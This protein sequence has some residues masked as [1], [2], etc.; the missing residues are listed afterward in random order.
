MN[1]HFFTAAFALGL[2]ALGWVAYGFISANPLALVM[3][4]LI[5]GVYA[6]GAWE[7]LQFRRATDTLVNA[8]CSIQAEVQDLGQ[9]LSSLA[10]HQS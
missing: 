7:L 1:R 8:L 6:L 3:T 2:L 4:V 9:W 10:A 5:A